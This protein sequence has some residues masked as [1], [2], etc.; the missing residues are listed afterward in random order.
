LFHLIESRPATENEIVAV[1]NL[2]EEEVVLAP[3]FSFLRFEER[4]EG[5]QPLSPT[6]Q[7]ILS[8]E[9]IG[10]FLQPFRI[11]AGEKGI[12]ITVLKTNNL[13]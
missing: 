13:M 5:G 8:R 2:S 4:R 7:Q 10:E 12:S 6:T 1:L 3:D 11:A 9:G